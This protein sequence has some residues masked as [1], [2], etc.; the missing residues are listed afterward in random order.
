MRHHIPAPFFSEHPP[1]IEGEDPCAS[2][3]RRRPGG[4]FEHLRAVP[5]RDEKEESRYIDGRH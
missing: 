2:C 3:S 5:P 1:G 4:V